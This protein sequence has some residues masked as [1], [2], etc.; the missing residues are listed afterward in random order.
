MNLAHNH[1]F[2]TSCSSSILNLRTYL[3]E[4]QQYVYRNLIMKRKQTNNQVFFFSFK[5]PI[6]DNQVVDFSTWF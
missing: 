3:T 5:H 2:T 4:I 6:D 1:A